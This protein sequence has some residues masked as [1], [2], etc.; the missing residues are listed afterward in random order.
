MQGVARVRGADWLIQQP[1]CLA[2]ALVCYAVIAAAAVIFRP[3][4][5]QPE[6]VSRSR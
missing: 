2:A 1:F 4:S 6:H 3:G 5:F